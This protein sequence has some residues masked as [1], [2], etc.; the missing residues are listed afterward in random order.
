MGKGREERVTE[1]RRRPPTPPAEHEGNRNP[2][3]YWT[4]GGHGVQTPPDPTSTPPRSTQASLL[5]ATFPLLF[6]QSAATSHATAPSL[7]QTPA[8][9]ASPGAGS[10]QV[11]RS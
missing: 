3:R 11:P 5:R 7:L 4:G 8:M 2:R 9:V 10:L 6:V 1:G